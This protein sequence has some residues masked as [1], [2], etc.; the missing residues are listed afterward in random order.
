MKD[1]DILEK[2]YTQSK[3]IAGLLIAILV[4]LVIGVSKL[5]SD[6][7]VDTNK[8]ESTNTE[9]DVSMFKEISASDVESETKD[10]LSLVYIGR[11]TCGWCVKFLPNI[12]QA[13]DE[14]GFKTL[15]IDIAKIIDFS[16]NKVS[17]QNSYDILESLTGDGYE[18]Y[19]KENFGATPMMLVIKDNKIV[20]AQTGYSDYETFESMLKDAGFN[21]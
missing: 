9:Y 10:K 7:V 15:Y 5:Y 1:K 12:Q 18:E 2:L 16:A 21:K 17:D 14:Y 3:I 13:Q 8:T 6:G 20:N 19:M 11:E 4:F